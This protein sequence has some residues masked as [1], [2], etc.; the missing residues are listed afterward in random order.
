MCAGITASA[1]VIVIMFVIALCGCAPVRPPA[2]GHTKTRV[3]VIT[4]GHGFKADP[5]F[6]LFA[7]NLDITFTHASQ[8]QAAEAYDRADLPS[9]DVVVLYDSPTE[10]TDAQKAQFMALLD[11]GVGLVVLHHALLSYQAWPAYARVVGGK[12]ILADEERDGAQLVRGSSCQQDA[13]RSGCKTDVPI[14]VTVTD[15]GHPVTNQLADFSITDELYLDV[16]VQPDIHPLLSTGTEVLAWTREQGRSR[17]VATVL[18]H[19]PPAYDNPGFRR[20]VAQSIRW[21][22][23]R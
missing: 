9:Y 11:R 7:A 14:A 2:D 10:I 15:R 8:G 1:R 13:G 5:F 21:A 12:Y 22:A 20:F 6:A 19:G 16:H 17:V 23:R 3:L 4:G 18:G